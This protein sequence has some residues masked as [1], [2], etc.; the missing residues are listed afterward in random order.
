M[1]DQSAVHIDRIRRATLTAGL[2][3]PLLTVWVSW[4]ILMTGV[5]LA[6]PL[7]A[8]YAQ[9]FDFST[10]VLTAVFTTYMVVLIPA[11]L[12]FGRLSDQVGRK[13]VI[14]AG[15]LVG[16]V[17]LVLFAAATSTAWLFAARAVQGLGVGMISGAAT[18]AL[19]ELDPR[20]DEQRPALLAGLAQ[21][22]GSGLGPLLA[23]ILAQWAPA[24]RH[25]SFL[26]MLGAT[27]AAAAFAL[28]LSD[29]RTA[30][31]SWSV[32]WPRVPQG[33]R[34]DFARVSITGGVVWAAVALCLSIVPSYA[35]DLLSTNNL[36]LL[37][38]IG[39]LALLMSCVTQIVSQRLRLRQRAGQALGLA[40]LTC[41]L[42]AL[43]VASPLHSLA[44]TLVGSAVAGAGHGFGFLNAQDEL[45]A[46]A[47]PDERGGV[48]AAFISCIYFTVATSVISTGLLDEWVSLS[49]AVSSVF[50]VLA[51]LAVVSTA[52]QLRR[53]REFVPAD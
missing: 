44:L 43:V 28:T 22:L 1:S 18:A 35:G 27:V 16:C 6:T 36:A 25:L 9:R 5:N 47:P 45:S 4:L 30:S 8:V 31:G 12:L 40:L 37:G 33:I 7:Y 29:P 24:P 20:R 14:V 51:V 32:Q 34:L 42:V 21:A 23:G 41:G 38:A 13:P 49:I 2:T 50:V 11:L 39:A 10:L 3:R 15:L 19:V 52:W 17:G 48:T 46:I 26:I 53:R